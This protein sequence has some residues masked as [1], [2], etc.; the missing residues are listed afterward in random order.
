M[1][2]AMW[3]PPKPTRGGYAPK[4]LDPGQRIE[5]TATTGGV[6]RDGRWVPTE[7]L[8]RS[9][10]IWSAGPCANSL[11]VQPDDAPYGEMAAVKLPSKQ[12]A[13]RG[14]KP[15][16]MPG[17]PVT[18]QRDTVRRCDN[19]SRR[20]ALFA[21]HETYTTYEYMKGNVERQRLVGIHCDPECPEIKHD[22]ERAHEYVATVSGVIRML[23]TSHGD[24]T[25]CRRCIYL[26]EP[27]E[28]AQA[29]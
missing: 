24:L 5:W 18:W 4:P 10:V 29:A 8:N 17:F 1:Q 9:G 16:E 26:T 28:V 27:A 2:I 12:A 7:V 13:E 6:H 14:N 20:G 25:F 21:E 23:L 11:W 3:T 15:F 22:I 19:L